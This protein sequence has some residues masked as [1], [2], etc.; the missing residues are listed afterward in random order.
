MGD[1]GGFSSFNKL[2]STPNWTFSPEGVVFRRGVRS[3]FCIRSLRR[4]GG[5]IDDYFRV[6]FWSRVLGEFRLF[7]SVREIWR[8]RPFSQF[9]WVDRPWWAFSTILICVTS[10]QKSHKEFWRYLT[11]AI[12]LG[13]GSQWAARVKV[14][15]PSLCWLEYVQVGLGGE[16]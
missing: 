11:C 7:F 8:V 16:V 6:W 14:D 3:G 15:L 12:G 5:Y 10:F 4:L 2:G 13:W 9:S 1:K